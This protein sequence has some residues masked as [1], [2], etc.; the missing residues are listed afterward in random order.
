[1]TGCAVN[2]TLTYDAVMPKD[3]EA[4]VVLGVSPSNTKITLHEAIVDNGFVREKSAFEKGIGG[5]PLNG[6]VPL[7]VKSDTVYK[8]SNII[9]YVGDKIGGVYRACDGARTLS[10]KA[11]PGTVTYIADINFASIDGKFKTGNR[12]NFSAARKYI[13]ENYPNLRGKIVDGKYEMV[14]PTEKCVDDSASSSVIVVPYKS[15]K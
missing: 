13:E 12:K 8:M 6:Y 14:T 3:G 11:E 10:F 2:S 9:L 15:K 5:K 4:I 7:V 1:M